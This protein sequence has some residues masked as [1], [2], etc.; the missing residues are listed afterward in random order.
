L[1]YGDNVIEPTLPAGLSAQPVLGDVIFVNESNGWA[2]YFDGRPELVSTTDGGKKFRII[3]PP[4]A[5]DLPIPPP[6]VTGLNG[7]LVK[8]PKSP[9]GFAPR[10]RIDRRGP[11]PIESSP[12]KS[13]TRHL[14]ANR[15]FPIH[16]RRS[17]HH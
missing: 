7:I 12:D 10:P 16:G 3:T 13:F 6:E 5:A 4:I 11:P 1:R 17:N 15:F 14:T 9:F 8:F 2:S